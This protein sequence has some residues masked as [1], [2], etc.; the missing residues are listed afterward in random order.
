MLAGGEGK[1]LRPLTAVTNKHLLP[2]FDKPMILHPIEALKSLGVNDIC[3]VT[4]G[5]SIGDFMKF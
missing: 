2:V 5:E 3:L 1:R 4:G